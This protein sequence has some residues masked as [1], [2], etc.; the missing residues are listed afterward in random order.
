MN[1]R[2]P[3]DYSE[4]YAGLDKILNS[5]MQQMKVF[6]EIGRL[7][8]SR[9]EKGAAVAA[10]EYINNQYPER[11][12]FSPRSLRRMR[13]FYRAYKNDPVL[14]DE[15]MKVCWSLNAVIIE[16]C[17]SAEERAW[18]IRAVQTFKWSKTE[19]V[20]MIRENAYKCID[21]EHEQEECCVETRHAVMRECRCTDLPF[22]ERNHSGA[23]EENTVMKKEGLTSL[24]I[25]NIANEILM[26]H[27]FSFASFEEAKEMI[28]FRGGQY[29]FDK[30]SLCVY[31]H[32]LIPDD[33]S[34]LGRVLTSGYA[35]RFDREAE[36]TRQEYATLFHLIAIHGQYADMEISKKVRPDFEL[37]G[38][39]KIG[40]EVTELTTPQDRVLATISRQNFGRG[41]SAEEIREHAI[42]KHGAK[43]NDY[44]YLDLEGTI[45]VGTELFDVLQKHKQYADEII[46][47]FNLYKEAFHLY[48]KFVILCDGQGAMC[49]TTEEDSKEILALA[50][51]KVPDMQ[52]FTV[53][54]LRTD[55][56]GK[57]ML[58]SFEI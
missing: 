45:A 37:S 51:N 32:D 49:L 40:V 28:S 10:A 14:M 8:D 3:I 58:D 52:G 48:D 35:E 24:E 2:K 31:S 46:K 23:I 54:I 38:Y 20:K 44:Q 4:M 18:Y 26:K 57:C 7:V 27:S 33:Y 47:K 5:D 39:E 19:L 21:F 30:L 56:S 42:K 13:D 11:Q 9:P 43:A 36:K 50:K 15:A 16:S 6:C 53:H 34:K 17:E 1:I 22:A 12:G 29:C 55:G 25:E 41:K